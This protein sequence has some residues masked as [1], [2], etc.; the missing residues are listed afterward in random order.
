MDAKPGYFDKQYG[1]YDVV[2]V[3]AGPAGLAAAAAAGEAGADVLLVD[4]QSAPGGAFGYAR[5]GSDGA[6]Q[7]HRP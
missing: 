4:D 5:L 6:A 7:Y 2:V 3:G 1:F